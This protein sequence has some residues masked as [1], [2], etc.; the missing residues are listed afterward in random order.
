[1]GKEFLAWC[2]I[3]TITWFCGFI[4]HDIGGYVAF[5]LT[6]IFVAFLGEMIKA[7]EKRKIGKRNS[8]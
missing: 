5:M 8:A 3:L 6:F 1:M 7:Y 2:I 4:S